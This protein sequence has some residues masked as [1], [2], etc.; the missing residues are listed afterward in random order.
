[1]TIL[2]CALLMTFGLPVFVSLGRH[3]A[4]VLLLALK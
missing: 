3:L 2:A 4:W 1:M